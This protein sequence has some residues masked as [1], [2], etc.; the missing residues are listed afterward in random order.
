[1]SGFK[2]EVRV[3]VSQK[4][5]T[6]PPQKLQPHDPLPLVPAPVVPPI[7]LFPIAQ[8]AVV[9]LVTAEELANMVALAATRRA[10]RNMNEHA[11][12][13]LLDIDL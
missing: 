13:G 10:Q 8:T 9:L 4:Q 1:M 12:G 11:V 5:M 3:R 6:T 7:A 2:S